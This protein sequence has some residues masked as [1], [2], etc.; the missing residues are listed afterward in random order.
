MEYAALNYI[1]IKTGFI[2]LFTAFHLPEPKMIIASI[3]DAALGYSD[4]AKPLVCIALLA[5][6]PWILI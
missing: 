5:F 6:V 2:L 1:R 3:A 4:N